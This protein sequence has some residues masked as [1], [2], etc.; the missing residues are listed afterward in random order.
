MSGIGGPQV[1]G[2]PSG[3]PPMVEM[4]AAPIRA[5]STAASRLTMYVLRPMW[6]LRRELGLITATGLLLGGGW[7]LGG[8]PVLAGLAVWLVAMFGGVP[9]VRGWLLHLLWYSRVIRR[10][11]RAAR[12]AG[13]A[14]Y[15][16]RIPRVMRAERTAAGERLRVRLPKGSAACEVD[17]RAPWLASSLAA[18][19]VVVTADEVNARYALVEVIRRDPFAALG[20]LV[21]PWAGAPDAGWM[22]C[23]WEPIPV[24]VAENGELVTVAL[25]SGSGD[26]P[27]ELEKPDGLEELDGGRRR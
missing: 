13:L 27:P 21:W 18:S 9:A 25:L 7:S 19:G 6:L 11:D 15:N 12:F 3:L 17:D 14:T 26:G 10:W 1:P 2:R 16:D 4:P 8:W 23:A 22:S 20:S 5:Q 24:G